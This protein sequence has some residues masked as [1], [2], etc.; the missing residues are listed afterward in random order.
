MVSVRDRGKGI[1]EED[2]P[3]V[4]DKFYQLENINATT[5]GSGLGMSIAKLLVERLGGRIWIESQI[6]EGTTVY[7]TLRGLI[8]S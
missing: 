4:F 5:E 6:G 8:E 7:F 2:I 3:K 1:Y